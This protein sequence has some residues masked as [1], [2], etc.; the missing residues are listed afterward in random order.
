MRASRGSCWRQALDAFFF[1]SSPPAAAQTSAVRR[2]V[3]GFV[4][5]GRWAD[6]W[7]CYNVAMKLMAT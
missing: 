1:G 2:A 7:L 4:G 5:G 3:V 6:G